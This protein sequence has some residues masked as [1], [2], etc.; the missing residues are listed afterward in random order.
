[1]EASSARSMYQRVNVTCT[2][3]NTEAGSVTIV[4]DT[5]PDHPQDFSFTCSAPLGNFLLDDDSD[6]TLSNSTGPITVAAG[7]YGCSEASVPNWSLQSATCSDGSLVSA[8][9]V[10]SGESVTCT[11]T[12]VGSGSISVIKNAVPNDAQ[13][14]GFGGSCFA[15]FNLDDDGDGTLPNTYGASHAIGSCTVAETGPPT[16]WSFTSLSCL[17]PDG[18]TTTAGPTAQSTLTLAKP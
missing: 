2:F 13:D 7:T 3:T 10:A 17:D 4:K 5:Q 6:G 1:M 9:N 15:P 18:G 8:I 11:F 12:N 16:G 14:F